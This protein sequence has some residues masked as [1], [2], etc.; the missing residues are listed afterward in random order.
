[1][2]YYGGNDD[3]RQADEIYAS[4]V[5]NMKRFVRWLVDNGRRVRLLVG[6]T[7]GSDDSVV[8]GDPGRPAGTPARS[9]AGAGRR[10]TRHLHSRS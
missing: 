8:A 5:E 4:Y 1:M 6:D 3:R 10:G 2:A 7:N 9:R